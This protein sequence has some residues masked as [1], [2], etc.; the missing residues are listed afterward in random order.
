MQRGEFM[1]DVQQG[2]IIRANATAEG[3][4]L[5]RYHGW[6]IKVLE[7]LQNSGGLS[8][9][10]ITEKLNHRRPDIRVYCERLYHDGFIEPIERWGWKITPA[11]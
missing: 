11:G 3:R 5:A 4:Q 9:A 1:Q 2:I 6:R 10:Q 8:V 7:V